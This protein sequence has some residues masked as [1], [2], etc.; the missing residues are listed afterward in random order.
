MR[1]RATLAAFLLVGVILAIAWSD[2]NS[3]VQGLLLAVLAATAVLV[4]SLSGADRRNRGLERSLPEAV[5][6]LLSE[7]AKPPSRPERLPWLPMGNTRPILL[8]PAADYHLDELVPLS[9]QLK[10]RGFEIRFATGDSPWE[11]TKRGLAR[12]P[13]LEVSQLPEPIV[14]ANNVTAVVT[15]KDTGSMTDWVTEVRSFGVPVIGKVEGAQ[16]FWD[17]DTPEERQPYRNLD[18]V[19]CQGQFDAEALSDRETAIVGSSRLERL[20]WAPPVKPP[21]EPL[22]LINLNFVYGVRTAD[23]KQWLETAIEGCDR[24]GIQYVISVHPAEKTDPL[25]SR[26]TRISASALLPHSSVLI[27][28]F[29]TVPLEAMARGVP[30]IYHNPHGERVQTFK[31]VMGAFAK[32]ISAAEL[33]NLL[34]TPNDPA[35]SVRLRAQNFMRRHVDMSETAESAERTADAILAEI[36]T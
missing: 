19:L 25:G 13:N 16:D 7:E 31:E 26:M 20:W 10:Q 14:V 1:R 15:L 4:A 8:V 12:Y 5:E 22:A 24:A 23:R 32:T 3:I 30:F 18:L 36:E 6:G 9:E 17:V 34:K 11:R 33:G 2:L 27:S 35:G 29:S 28:R 21:Q